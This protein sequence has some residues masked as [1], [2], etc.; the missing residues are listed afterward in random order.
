MV[1]LFHSFA[2]TFS[3]P[4]LPKGISRFIWLTGIGRTGVELFFV[5]SG[6]LITGILLDSNGRAD[7]YRRFYVRRA[8]RILP[9]YFGLLV[10]LAS[11]SHGPWLAARVGWRFV[12]LSLFYLSN[13][14]PL[15]GV[16]VQYPPLWSLAVEEH[17]YAIWPV[18]VRRLRL[19][20]F[21]ICAAGT[22]LLVP[23]IRAIS[24]SRYGMAKV[25]FYT[26]CNADALALGAL[27]AII[28][29]D[30][31]ATRARL[32]SLVA[33]TV[34]TALLILLFGYPF[35]IALGTTTVGFSL[36]IVVLDLLFAALI[37]VFLLVGTTS[38]K[39]LVNRPVLQF[40][41]R[42]SYGLYLFHLLVFQLYDA[43]TARFV[44]AIVAH[45]G[46]FSTILLR[47]L[48]A[49]GASI[50]FAYLS[51]RYFEEPFLALKD[52]LSRSRAESLSPSLS[53]R[54]VA[55]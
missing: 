30:T 51:R 21:A 15:F 4:A 40:L 39:A 22:C 6:F 50:A 53:P 23:V 45:D 31:R 55:A 19:S 14:T 32:W 43:F 9:A 46:S 1:L 49:S 2:L 18:V 24:I 27:L 11:L 37:L 12:L 5:L 16:P 17:F 3:P 54:S 7:F 48:V 35:G 28:A 26:W 29:R 42:I 8:L 25:N 20:G 44:P 52:R 38:W 33:M 41:G 10:I 36:R 13:V 47:F 34:C